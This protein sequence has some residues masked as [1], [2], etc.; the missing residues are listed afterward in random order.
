[1]ANLFRKT[2]YNL[3]ASNFIKR[4]GQS[5]IVINNEF[6]G[7]QAAGNVYNDALIIS[8]HHLASSLSDVIMNSAV[9]LSYDAVV[10][11]QNLADM[12]GVV[13]VSSDH[14]VSNQNNSVLDANASLN[15]DFAVSVLA[16]VDFLNT[17][18]LSQD[19]AVF[20][21]VDAVINSAISLMQDLTFLSQNT[22]DQSV[23][24]LFVQDST[25][26][27]L[28]AIDI[29]QSVSLNSEN[30]ISGFNNIVSDNTA[31]LGVG[32]AYEN[33]AGLDFLNT[34]ALVSDNNFQPGSN[35]SI[36]SQVNLSNDVNTEIGSVL[37]AT[38]LVNLATELQTSSTASLNLDTVLNLITDFQFYSE[39]Q[40]DATGI[41]NL[42]SDN[43]ILGNGILEAN[44]SADLEICNSINSIGNIN[45]DKS[46]MLE[47]SG[48]SDSETVLLLSGVI[49]LSGD[50]IASLVGF[51]HINSTV[52]LDSDSKVNTALSVSMDEDMSLET[53][54]SMMDNAFEDYLN[55]IVLL[56]ENDIEFT[57]EKF[58][59]V[60]IQLFGLTQVSVSNHAALLS[61]IELMMNNQVLFDSF[62]EIYSNVVLGSNAEMLV[63]SEVFKIINELFSLRLDAQSIFEVS[64][65]FSDGVSL[66]TKSFIEFLSEVIAV[67]YS[68]NEILQENSLI[69]NTLIVKSIINSFLLKNIVMSKISVLSLITDAI[70]FDSEITNTIN[71]KSKIK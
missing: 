31:S 42:Q 57:Y 21:Q 53:S 12:A 10:S 22:L 60:V 8:S 62:Q 58:S 52:L 37:E 20:N 59:D 69:T 44:A 14:A 16:K 70:E 19:V 28:I 43:E 38:A 54:S 33:T 23:S 45:F 66:S 18:V 40:N 64:K 71:L 9:T 27:V 11:L 49:S 56:T 39:N 32:V 5:Y 67:D 3:T 13:L 24:V 7:V 65:L 47:S 46:I 29:K 30:N 51:I 6:F 61:Q 48:E 41:V 68:N 34:V 2:R 36:I 26:P 17:I 35:L 55:T 4:S 15:S 25:M 1:M 50:G 63:S